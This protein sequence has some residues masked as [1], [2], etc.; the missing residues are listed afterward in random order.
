M[1]IPVNE[2][3]LNG[4]EK[5]YLNECIDTGWISSEGPF[6]KR[7]E[8]DFSAFVGA[9]YGSAVANGTAALE[10]ALYALGIGEGDEVIMPSFTIISCAVACLRLG[11][12]PV[13]VDIEPE[14]W[15]MDIE[16]VEAKITPRTK[17]VMPVHIYGHPVDM[18]KLFELKE[19]YG[20]KILEDAS[21]VHGAE[22]FS[23]RHNKW[24]RCGAMGDAATFSFYA[25]KIITSGE[26]GI[27]V[28][29][30]EK[31]IN[32]ANSY[33]NLCFNAKERFSHENIGYNFRM[34]NLQAAVAVA[35]LEQVNNFINIKRE[36]GAYYADKFSG[37]KQLRFMPI[38]SWAKSVY[39]MYS[40]E[41]NPE[42]GFNAKEF[43]AELKEFQIGTRPFF[44]GLHTQPALL[45]KNLFKGETYKNTDYAYKYGFYLPSGLTITNQQIDY[46]VESI[47]KIFTK[48]KG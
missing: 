3:L 35:Q 36:R 44:K 42:A 9:S 23:K 16:Q 13:L 24:L 22:Y 8:K 12:I 15:C 47:Q 40:V 20:F 41:L 29:D 17:V 46:V 4:N 21:E 2:P 43:M 7:L 27:V 31:V 28:S 19:K 26:G 34:S 14:T 10:T 5:K 39:W 32:R 18:D 37:I 30:N 25:N 11:A 45:E 48:G 38:K 1:G 6:V 33:R